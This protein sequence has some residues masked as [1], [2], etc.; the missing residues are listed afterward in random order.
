MI[1]VEFNFADWNSDDD[2]ELISKVK[3]LSKENDKVNY[4]TR[5]T[6]FDW[7]AVTFKRYSSKDC[8]KRFKC[9]LK[10]VRRYRTF[11]EIIKDVELNVK[12]CPVK[13][14]LNSYQLFIQEQLATAKTSGDF[15]CTTGKYIFFVV[16]GFGIGE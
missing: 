5:L 3:S 15:V 2:N 6:Q 4:K 14:P 16:G 13:K 12:R 10:N 8:E 11:S 7:S 1:V 9:H